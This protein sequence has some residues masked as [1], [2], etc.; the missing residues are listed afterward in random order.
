MTQ[1][2]VQIGLPLAPCFATECVI[3]SPE[4]NSKLYAFKMQRLFCCFGGGGRTGSPGP[5]SIKVADSPSTTSCSTPAGQYKFMFDVDDTDRITGVSNSGKVSRDF[6]A[7][8]AAGH[9]ANSP[10]APTALQP[11]STQQ[12]G[13]SGS[14][15]RRTKSASNV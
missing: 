12:I 6:F 7:F 15:Q 14:E 1:Q 13:Q 9:Q 4:N 10:S 5:E 2:R 11:P 8:S 3:T